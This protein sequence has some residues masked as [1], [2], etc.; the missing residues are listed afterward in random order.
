MI[1][2]LSLLMVSTFKYDTLPKINKKNIVEHPVKFSLFFIIC[3]AVLVTK[4]AAL[5]PLF[6]IYTLSGV[7]RWI[8]NLI[9][10]ITRQNKKID[11][12]DDAEISSIDV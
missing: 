4:G 5:F 3:T 8:I 10:N 11:E 9:K 1:I 2:G 12:E 6:I 7:L